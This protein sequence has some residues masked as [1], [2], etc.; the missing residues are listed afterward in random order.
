MDK[1]TVTAAKPHQNDFGDKF[2]K[3]TGDT[4]EVTADVAAS[5]HAAGW[6]ADYEGMPDGIANEVSRRKRAGKSSG[7]AGKGSNTQD[8]GEAG[9]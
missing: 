4:Y 6:I 3:E 1:I 5:L 2:S 7:A 8:N 9:A